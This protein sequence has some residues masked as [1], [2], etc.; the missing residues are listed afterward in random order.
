[1]KKNIIFKKTL[2]CII[3]VLFFSAGF[4]SI[5]SSKI[6]IKKTNEKTMEISSTY[7]D[8]NTVAISFHTIEKTSSKKQDIA[9]SIDDAYFVFD[10]FKELKYKIIFDPMSEETQDLKNEFV[11][12]LGKD[13]KNSQIFIYQVLEKF[14]ILEKLL[15]YLVK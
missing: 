2:V 7:L 12:K 15:F 8:Q 11:E 3:I 4:A 6:N 1:M 14:L 13:N 10:M 9:L 5:V